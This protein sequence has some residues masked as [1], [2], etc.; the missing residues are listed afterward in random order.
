MFLNSP[1]TLYHQDL[2]QEGGVFS[3]CPVGALSICILVVYID[4]I[5]SG[6]LLAERKFF[7]LILQLS[8]SK[9]TEKGTPHKELK[10]EGL[11]SGDA[12][13]LYCTVLDFLNNQWG[14]RN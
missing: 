7:P 8:E 3:V 14:I 10:G 9:S 4:D 1:R 11:I 13:I 6:L 5:M 2:R 12:I